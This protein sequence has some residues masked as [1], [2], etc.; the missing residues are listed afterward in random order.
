M[1]RPTNRILRDVFLPDW[2]ANM[3]AFFNET[4]ADLK[5]YAQESGF[6][7]WECPEPEISESNESFQVDFPIHGIEP[8]S[9]YVEA[10]EEVVILSGVR[11]CTPP[12]KQSKELVFFRRL[13]RLPGPV[14]ERNWRVFR[15]AEGALKLIVQKS[16]ETLELTPL[17]PANGTVNGKSL[18]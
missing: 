2:D 13:V 6:P 5:R 18:P 7:D 1:K 3:E 17:G 14:S 11:W 16:N 9:I 10:I 8:E 15:K 4:L 12:K